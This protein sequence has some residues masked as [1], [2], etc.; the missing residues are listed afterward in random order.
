MKS[1]NPIKPNVTLFWFRR[2]LRLEDNAFTTP[3]K[4]LIP[5]SRFSFLTVLFST[6][7]KTIRTG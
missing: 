4:A 3:S 7:W 2:D 6:C 1:G 5:F